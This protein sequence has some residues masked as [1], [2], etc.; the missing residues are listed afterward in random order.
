MPRR[1][2]A[3]LL[4]LL[5]ACGT[6]YEVP[7]VG[8]A[9][10]VAAPSRAAEGVGIGQYRTVAARVENA[11]EAFCREESPGRPPV[12]CDFEIR[13]LSDPDLPPNAF[14]TLGPNGRPVVGVTRALLA[15]AGGPHELAFVLSHEAGHHVAGHIPRQQQSQAL[16]A[17]ILGGLLSV[18][19]GEGGASQEQVSQAMDLGAFLGG[20]AYSQTFELEADTVGAFIA[21]RAGYDPDRGALM[22]TRPSLQG[23]GG[24]LSSHPPSPQRLAT[25]ARAAEEI[26][27]QRAAGLIPRPNRL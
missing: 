17:L 1:P 12:Q 19:S 10:P 3:A 24:L 2:T 27:R 21:A 25:V 20:R 16:G 15:E 6:T 5:A 9:A 4:L 11:A 14:Q 26:R 18:A 8:P 13:L 23:G 22:F 7:A